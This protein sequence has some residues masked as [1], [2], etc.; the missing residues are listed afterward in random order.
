M[1]SKMSFR[2]IVIANK[3]DHFV[4]YEEDTPQAYDVF[5]KNDEGLDGLSDYLFFLLHDAVGEKDDSR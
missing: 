2:K 3:D 5:E 1:S 4:V